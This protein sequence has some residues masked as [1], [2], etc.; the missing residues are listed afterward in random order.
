MKSVT[1]VLMVYV[2]L[3]IASS[4]FWVWFVLSKSS[5]AV[6]RNTGSVSLATDP[7]QMKQDA[8]LVN[9]KTTELTGGVTEGTKAAG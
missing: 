9:D 5:L 1:A 7:D 6:R 2:I 4:I 8:E 3:V